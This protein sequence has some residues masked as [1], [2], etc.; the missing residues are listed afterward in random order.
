M[1][2][3]T[4]ISGD[5]SVTRMASK[6]NGRCAYCLGVMREG[7]QIA[8]FRH[9]V[10][11]HHVSYLRERGWDKLRAMDWECYLKFLRN[12]E[13]HRCAYCG[14][15]EDLTVDHIEPR[16]GVNDVPR[17][18]VTSCRS[19]NSSKNRTPQKHFIEESPRAVLA[20]A[21]LT[22]LSLFGEAAA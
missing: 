10:H 15:S 8:L 14:S 7:R 2:S 21:E 20:K 18:L 4:I 17:N 1:K 6:Y 22:Q 16:N 5:A 11:V 13:F 12:S 9:P 3:R 19:C